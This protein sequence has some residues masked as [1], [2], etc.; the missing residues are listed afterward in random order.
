MQGIRTRFHGETMRHMVCGTPIMVCAFE[1]HEFHERPHTRLEA[2]CVEC[3]ISF[4]MSITDMQVHMDRGSDW[5][6][7]F[8][9]AAMKLN[10]AP[11]DINLLQTRA[12]S[13]DESLK[14]LLAD[15][16]AFAMVDLFDYFRYYPMVRQQEKFRYI[17][18]Q[19]KICAVCEHGGHIGSY[20]D[21]RF[22][23]FEPC[24]VGQLTLVAS[25]VSEVLTGLT[26]GKL[27][28]LSQREWSRR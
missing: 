25:Q 8:F 15:V 20:R 9:L 12:R 6:D 21:H 18:P 13:V 17:D 1:I 4:F 19:S 10:T 11:V 5:D 14:R 24:P 7:F 23:T 16:T 22:N 28:E 2:H 3:G 27:G 26:S